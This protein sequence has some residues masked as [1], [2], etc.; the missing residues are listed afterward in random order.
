MVSWHARAEMA[1]MR[2]QRKNRFYA[3]PDVMRRRPS[4]CSPRG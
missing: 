3:D 1:W 4:R 2:L